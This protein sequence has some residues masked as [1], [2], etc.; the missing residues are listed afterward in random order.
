M[1][2]KYYREIDCHSSIKY[3][4]EGGDAKVLALAGLGIAAKKSIYISHFGKYAEYVDLRDIEVEY[5]SPEA[6]GV[7]L[8][9]RISALQWIEHILESG[10]E[11]EVQIEAIQAVLKLH[12]IEGR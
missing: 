10:V 9:S 1:K 7:S 5:D 11:S 6:E 8:S 2:V 12:A 3:G 4:I